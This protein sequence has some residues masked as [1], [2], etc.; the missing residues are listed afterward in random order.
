MELLAIDAIAVAQRI[1]R[2][3]VSSESFQQL[4]GSPFRGEICSHS[5]M[6]GTPPVVLKNHKSVIV[7]TTK[8]SAETKFSMW[9]YRG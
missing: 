6:N 1:V 9:F 3:T 5:K 4:S 8:K 7:G 2:R